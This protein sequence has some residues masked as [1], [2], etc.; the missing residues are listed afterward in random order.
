MAPPYRM[1]MFRR[2]SGPVSAYGS[3]DASGR[4]ALTVIA[5][6]YQVE[7]SKTDYPGP[8]PQAVTVPPSLTNVD[9]TFPQ[10]YTISG[11]VKDYDGTPVQVLTFA[12]LQALSPHTAP[13]PPMAATRSPSSPARTRS[14]SARPVIPARRG[15]R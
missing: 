3:T 9:F 10:R 12:P 5:G 6:T 8:P 14:R 4:Y 1:P 13:P 2:I 11:T 15:R 7:A